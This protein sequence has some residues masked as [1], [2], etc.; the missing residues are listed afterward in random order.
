MDVENLTGQMTAGQRLGALGLGLEPTLDN[1]V[2]SVSSGPAL[3]PSLR[4]SLRPS[5]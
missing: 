2:C 4:P 5:L 1:G 3:P